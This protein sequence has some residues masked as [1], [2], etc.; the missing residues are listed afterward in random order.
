MTTAPNIHELI[1]EL[2]QESELTNALDEGLDDSIQ[3]D[4]FETSSTTHR[5][6]LDNET[7]NENSRFLTSSEMDDNYLNHVKIIMIF[8][9]IIIL[10]INKNNFFFIIFF[11]RM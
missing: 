11:S 7:S 4:P 2:S 3:T 6:I 5:E 10:G 8:I 9:I 1:R